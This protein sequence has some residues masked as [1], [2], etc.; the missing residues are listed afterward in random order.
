MSQINRL[1]TRSVE[2]ESTQPAEGEE[3]DGRTLEGYGAVFDMPTRINSWEG[4]FEERIS[5]GAFSKTLSERKPIMQYDHGRDARTGSVPIGAIQELREDPQGLYVKARLFDNPIVEPIRQAIEGGAISGMSFKFNVKRDEWRDGAGQLLRPEELGRLLH[6]A[7]D[8]GPLQRN[9][10]EVQLFEVGPVATPAYAGTSVGVRSLTDDEREALVEEYRKTMDVEDE[11]VTDEV[12][13][14][15]AEERGLPMGSKEEVQHSWVKLHHDDATKKSMTPDEKKAMKAKLLAAAVKFDIKLHKDPLPASWKK[16]NDGKFVKSDEGETDERVMTTESLPGHHMAEGVCAKCGADDDG[17]DC[18]PS[19]LT[20]GLNYPKDTSETKSSESTGAAHEGTPAATRTNDDAA[21][22]G[23]SSK[24]DTE[25][26]PRKA[27]P[28][29]KSLEELRARLD[30]ISERMQEIGSD[31]TRSLE[32]AE[33]TEFDTLDTESTEIE[34]S[35]EQIEKRA[36]RLKT[37][38]SRGSAERGSDRGPA[39]HKKTED[40]YDVAEIRMASNGSEDFAARLRD[41]AM[42]AVEAAKFGTKSREEAQGEAARLLD[43][44]DNSNG[45]LAMRYLVTG[46]ADYERAFTKLLRHGSDVMCTA[47]ERQALVRAQTLGTDANGG[48]AVPF[49]L[50]PTVMLTNAGATN[51]IRNLARVEQIVGKQWQGVTSAGVSVTRAG[52]TSPTVSDGS[53][54]LAQ[55]VVSTNRVQG[56]VPFTI[57]IDLS[58]NALRSEITRVL[59]DAKAREEDSFITGDGTGTNPEGILTGASTTVTAG[60]TAAFAANDIYNLH[61]AIPPRFENKATFLA[62]KGIYNK[63]R[64]FDT[65]GGAQLWAHIGDGRPNGL[66]GY[67]AAYASAMSNSLATGQKIMV[68][69]DF[70]NFLIVDRIGMT[71]ELVPHLFD[72]AGGNN[73]PTGQRGVY[74]IWMNNSKTLIPGAFRTLV[75]G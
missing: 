60:G 11:A 41:N 22:E 61:A 38:A 18:D 21:R 47:E 14:D 69:G 65:S 9:I 50:D 3:S 54:S 59:V 36:E 55:P 46:S 52:E 72:V 58:W 51:P 35:I 8:R 2:F 24:R 15:D 67:P 37:L 16:F 26:T 25:T 64:Q 7:G 4:D 75:T 29:A 27:V 68:L 45:D 13:V 17:A 10:K 1:C 19:K 71:V 6:N 70:S 31:E 48:F 33:Q 39:F 30:E 49:Q 5:P 66:M 73:R 42:R 53:F 44:V 32:D 20:S 74:A 43:E 12:V 34:R 62:H 63:V 23:T 56:F 40:I 57:E 28:M